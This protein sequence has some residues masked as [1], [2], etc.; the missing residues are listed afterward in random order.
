MLAALDAEAMLFGPDGRRSLKCTEFTTGIFETKLADDEIIEGIRIPKLST[1]ARWGYLK[2]CRKSGEFASGLAVAVADRARGHYRIVLGAANGAPLLLGAASQALADNRREPEALRGAIA[3]DLDDAADRHFDEFQRNLLM[4]A[5]MRAVRAGDGVTAIRLEVNGAAIADD[6]PP[7]LSLADFLRERRNLTGT[8]LGCEHGVCGACTVLVDGEPARACLMLAV[9]CDGREVRTIEGFADDPVM[10]ALRDCFHRHH[11]LQCGFC[12]PAMLITARDLIRARAGRLRARD[13]RRSRRQHLPLHRL[14]QHRRRDRR[15]SGGAA[16]GG[17]PMANDAWG[18]GASLLRK[19][20]RAPPARPRR[21]RRR[22]SNCRARWRWPSSAARMRMPAFAA[23]TVPP[24]GKGRVFTA[25]TCRASSRSASSPR[26][27]APSRRPGRRW[28][29]TRCAMSARR[30]PPA[31]PPTRAEAEDLAAAVIVD[32]EVLAAVVDAAARHARQPPSW[33]TSNG[34]TTSTS[35]G[36]SKAAISTP[37][38]ARP[39][40]R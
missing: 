3:A 27:P 4:V 22:T 39:R 21:I 34:A 18:V 38:R 26:R 37:R 17:R 36:C 2:L 20:G 29:P 8:H 25:A 16:P 32:F 14:H 6:V 15:G 9:A 24:E 30:S 23:I 1:D 7:R 19:R 35:S 40:S 10:A 31:S 11:G 5:A 13:P 33:F 12:T 28:P